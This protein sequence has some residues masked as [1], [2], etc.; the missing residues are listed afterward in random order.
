MHPSVAVFALSQTEVADRLPA[1]EKEPDSVGEVLSRARVA[2]VRWAQTPLAERLGAIKSLRHSLAEKSAHFSSLISSSLA[3][4]EPGTLSAEVLPLAEAAKFLERESASILR[5]KTLTSGSRPFFLRKVS[6]TQRYEPLGVVLIIGPANYPLLL[7]GVQALQAL[8]AGNAVLVKPGRGGRVVAQYLAELAWQAGVP[9]DLFV[10]L[11]EDVQTACRMIDEGVDK[12]VLTGSVESGRAVLARAAKR[13]TPAI[14]ELSGCDA[15]FILAGADLDKAAKAL[16]FGLSLNGSATCIAP[17][18]VFIDRSNQQEFVRFLSQSLRGAA[19]VHLSRSITALVEELFQDALRSGAHLMQGDYVAGSSM[20][21]TVL[22][23]ALPSMRVASADVF[24]P[25]CCLL[26]FDSESEAIAAAT[27]CPYALGATVFGPEQQARKFAA[28]VPAGVVVV[29]DMIVP[30][31]DP[32]LTFG[33]KGASGFGKTRGAEG[34]LQMTFLKS[35]V[36]QREMRLR[37][38]EPEHPR[39]EQLFRSYIAVVHGEGFKGR[40]VA[41]RNLLSAAIGK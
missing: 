7:P 6:I 23:D 37:H 41:M 1:H 38:L 24:A 19:P 18:R 20:R 11:P 15:M 14:M 8:V 40:A 26:P 4:S 31:A 25:L 12:I 34:L 28:F 21:P 17:R 5:T 3:R 33:G 2:Q 22:V 35:I 30:T 13:L 10:V 36:V 9:K 16:A 32:R 29:N 39:A 27:Q